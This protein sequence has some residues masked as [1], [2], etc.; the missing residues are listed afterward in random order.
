MKRRSAVVQLASA[1]FW[2]FHAE[3]VFAQSRKT[4]IRFVQ[5]ARTGW[6][7]SAVLRTSNDVLES[8]VVLVARLGERFFIP[9]DGN[10][11]PT[12]ALRDRRLEDPR[13][14]E[15]KVSVELRPTP[16]EVYA[17]SCLPYGGSAT[18]DPAEALRSLRLVSAR[19]ISA[20]L[21]ILGGFGWIP[22]GYTSIEPPQ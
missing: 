10:R 4:E 17:I 18:G 9:L 8:Q 3:N 20:V 6:V 14:F 21:R 1:L 19:D 2:A 5:Y 7:H 12:V 11:R 16:E 15:W 22:A 13:A